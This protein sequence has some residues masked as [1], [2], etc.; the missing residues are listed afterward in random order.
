MT[1]HG[2]LRIYSF[3]LTLSTVGLECI[4]DTA[5]VQ[6]WARSPSLTLTITLK[7]TLTATLTRALT[8][9]QTLAITQTQTHAGSGGEL[10]AMK[11]HPLQQYMPKDDVLQ[12][13]EQTLMTV[14]NQAR[15]FPAT[16]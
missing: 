7:I 4:D 11:L 3:D 2:E 13:A 6:T 5:G 16:F 9:T 15:T 12:T 10:L 8:Q 14:V 1:P